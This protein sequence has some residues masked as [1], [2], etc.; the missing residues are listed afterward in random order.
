MEQIHEISDK[1]G[2]MSRIKMWKIKQKGC[3]KYEASDPVAK[4]DKHGK[5]L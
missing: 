2:N 5:E 1:S 3:P 4:L